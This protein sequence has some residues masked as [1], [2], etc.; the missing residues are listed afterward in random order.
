MAT[1]LLILD[2]TAEVLS[3]LRQQGVAAITVDNRQVPALAE[4]G[5]GFVAWPGAARDGRSF[6][7]QALLDGAVPRAPSSRAWATK[8]RPSRARLPG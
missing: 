5:A 1:P 6:V 4:Q 7:A 3:W 8:L 2:T